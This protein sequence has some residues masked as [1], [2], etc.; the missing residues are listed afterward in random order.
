VTRPWTSRSF[1]GSTRRK[2]TPWSRWIC[3]AGARRA[4]QGGR[5]GMPRRWATPPHSWPHA[6]SGVHHRGKETVVA[7][8]C[9]PDREV[10]PPLSWRGRGPGSGD[11]IPNSDAVPGPEPSERTC[12][13]ARSPTNQMLYP[14][15]REAP[16]SECHAPRSLR[17]T[18]RE[19]KRIIIAKRL[20]KS[21][22]AILRRS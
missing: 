2:R 4:R 8:R 21:R 17:T 10:H 18:M 5:R 12:S 19:P 9:S 11:T 3:S 15:A 22:S 1:P 6:V 16:D 20:C 7:R 13:N 14:R